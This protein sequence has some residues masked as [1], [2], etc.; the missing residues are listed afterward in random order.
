MNRVTLLVVAVVLLA[1]CN[2][3][4]DTAAGDPTSTS[5]SQPQV[6]EDTPAATVTVTAPP[7]SDSPAPPPSGL[8]DLPA[9]V[10]DTVPLGQPHTDGSGWQITV[11][12]VRCDVDSAIV[13]ESA[14]YGT[15]DPEADL[16]VASP[17][18]G[19]RFCV[20]AATVA[21]VWTAP[22]SAADLDMTLTD[23][24]GRLFAEHDD[25]TPR[26]YAGNVVLGSDAAETDPRWCCGDMNPGAT[27]RTVFLFALP[28]DA[29][30][31]EVMVYTDMYAPGWRVPLR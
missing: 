20:V 30:S 26:Q 17:P 9:P 13:E 29:E 18:D 25:S 22:L 1:G 12:E 10:I 16:R 6:T 31:Q 24:Q 11:D 15:G 14:Y 21:N 23:T 2:P 8:D 28:D 7:E 27:E 3:P 19:H 5:A 4:P